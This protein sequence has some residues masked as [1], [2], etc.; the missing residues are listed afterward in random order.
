MKPMKQ[1][2]IRLICL[3][4]IFTTANEASAQLMAGFSATPTQ[5]CA[6]LLVR[7]RDTSS[8]GPTNWKWDLG[9]GTTSFLQNP[10]ATYFTP[11]TYNVKLV[12]KNA[13]NADSVVKSQ[14]ITVW[15]G[16]TANFSVSDSSGCYPLGVQFHDMSTPGDST[17]TQWAWHFGDGNVDVSNNPNPSHTYINSGVFSVTLTVTNGHGCRKSITRPNLIRITNGTRANF[18]WTAPPSCTPPTTVTFTNTSTGTG[19]F[20]YQWNFGNGT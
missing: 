10:V 19:T 8:G 20:T 15:N 6:P 1:M 14:Y 2:L 12:I 17:I 3:I 18:T 9:N 5:G 4:A 7:F 13:S 11:G 16:P